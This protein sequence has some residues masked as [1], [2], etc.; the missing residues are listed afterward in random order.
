MTGTA[1]QAKGE[2]KKT[3]RLKVTQIPTNKKCIRK[4]LP[5]RVFKTQ[6][7]KRDA[8]LQEIER[9]CKDGRSVLVG[10]PSVEASEALGVALK[11]RGI[12]HATLNALHHE[13]ESR[14]RFARWK[15]RG[16]VTIATNMAGRGTDILLTDEVRNAGGL[17]VI[18][19]EFHS[20]KRIDRQLIGRAARQGDPGGYQFFLSLEDELLRCRDF[21]KIQKKQNSARPNAKGEL[22]R[23]WIGFF[24]RTQKFLEK[25]HYK[26]RKNLLKQEKFRTEAY[27]RMGIDPY[28]ELTES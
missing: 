18:A 14:Y 6:D 19:T 28:L 7:A 3:Y 23:T 15:S 2:L 20:S 25:S 16:H 22:S 8:I 4:G 9:V 1:V 27:E 5:T 24:K 12:R 26:Q 11:E 21:R 17:H 13:Q 10:T